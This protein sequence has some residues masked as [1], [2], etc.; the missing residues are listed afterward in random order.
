MDSTVSLLQSRAQRKRTSANLDETL[1]CPKNDSSWWR[2]WIMN[3]RNKGLYQDEANNGGFDCHNAHSKLALG[4]QHP[5]RLCVPKSKSHQYLSAMGEKV[6]ASFPIQAT[7]HFYNDDS[8]SEEEETENMEEEQALGS[9][10]TVMALD[11]RTEL[12][13]ENFK[14]G[15]TLFWK[16]NS[17]S[18]EDGSVAHRKHSVRPSK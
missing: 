12:Q 4:F 9:T 7:I 6:L 5:V 1:R 14:E 8:D 15:D 16:Q 11:K 18:K 10:H 17:K 2:P 13:V 3:M